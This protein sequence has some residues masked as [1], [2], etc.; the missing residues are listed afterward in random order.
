M[1]VLRDIF[2]L[3][4]IIRRYVDLSLSPNL[5]YCKALNG[6]LL[7]HQFFIECVF[8]NI[9]EVANSIKMKPMQKCLICSTLYQCNLWS[10]DSSIIF[11]PFV[12]MICNFHVTLIL[13]YLTSKI[14]LSNNIHY[15]VV[16]IWYRLPIE[17]KDEN[18]IKM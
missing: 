16:R 6:H 10:L 3:C 2:V 1:F 12:I 11:I 14:S 17:K 8:N 18:F 5:C 4:L 7:L 9:E 13:L 15:K